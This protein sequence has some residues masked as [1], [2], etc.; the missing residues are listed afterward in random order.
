M[1]TASEQLESLPVSSRGMGSVASAQPGR[2]GS[3]R[4]FLPA[5]SSC[6]RRTHGVGAGRRNCDTESVLPAPVWPG[7]VA[8]AWKA[9]LAHETLPETQKLPGLG[10]ALQVQAWFKLFRLSFKLSDTGHSGQ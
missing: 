10:L 1:K 3:D 5:A 4:R 9:R 8:P 7:S 2:R 6:S